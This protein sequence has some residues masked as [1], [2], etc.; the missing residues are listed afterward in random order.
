MIWEK[1]RKKS[2][3]MKILFHFGYNIPWFTVLEIMVLVRWPVDID[4]RLKYFNENLKYGRTN[5]ISN[6][7]M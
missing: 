2:I 3:T 7:L 1:K 4:N 5:K 6:S